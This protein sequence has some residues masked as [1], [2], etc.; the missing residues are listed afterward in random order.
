MLWKKP[1]DYKIILD[2]SLLTTP[3]HSKLEAIKYQDGTWKLRYLYRTNPDFDNFNKTPRNTRETLDYLESLM[4]RVMLVKREF[5]NLYNNLELI[6][7][8]IK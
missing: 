1:T 2:L 8:K 6:K 7:E 4:K 3:Y 5:K